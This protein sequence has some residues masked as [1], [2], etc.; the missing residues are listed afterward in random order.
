MQLC[1]RPLTP[2]QTTRGPQRPHSQSRG[3]GAE[4]AGLLSVSTGWRRM[5]LS[6]FSL[7]L[8]RGICIPWRL[9]RDNGYYSGRRNAP[10]SKAMKQTEHKLTPKTS[11]RHPHCKHSCRLLNPPATAT[12]RNLTQSLSLSKAS[13]PNRSAA[14]S[15]LANVSGGRCRACSGLAKTQQF[16]VFPRFSRVNILCNQRLLAPG[17]GQPQEECARRI[18]TSLLSHCWLRS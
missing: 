13:D 7:W 2:L 9:F 17:E 15:S 5:W 4:A 11:L 6:L 18:C 8:K 3:A 1:V 12:F 10:R 14:S 16:L